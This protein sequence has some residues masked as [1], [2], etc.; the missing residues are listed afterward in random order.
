MV[1][2]PHCLV[3]GSAPASKWAAQIEFSGLSKKE[4]RQKGTQNGETVRKKM[5]EVWEMTETYCFKVSKAAVKKRLTFLKLSPFVD[6]LPPKL[7][8]TSKYHSFYLPNTLQ[9]GFN[10]NMSLGEV[11]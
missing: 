3:G 11:S 6:V 9:Q 1:G 5:G 4:G 2:S 10:F 7:D 8:P